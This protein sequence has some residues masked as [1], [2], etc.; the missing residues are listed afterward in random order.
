MRLG[1]ARTLRLVAVVGVMALVA[2]G[3]NLYSWGDNSLGQL[4][5]GSTDNSS[6]PT[7]GT[8]AQNWVSIDTGGG[9][10]A[11]HTC[12]VRTDGTARCFGSNSN[13]QLGDGTN[14]AHTFPA[15]AGSDT[16]WIAI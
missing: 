16:D 15:Q 1:L 6:V 14:S 10:S 2:G 12:G 7:L 5:N 9:A 13:G 8:V 3:C 4:G 11:S